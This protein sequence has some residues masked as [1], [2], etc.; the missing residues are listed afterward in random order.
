MKSQKI[1]AVGAGAKGAGISTD[2]V[3]AGPDVTFIE[4]WPA[5]AEA[6]RTNGVLVVMPDETLVTPARPVRV[7]V[8]QDW[9]KGRCGQGDDSNRVRRAAAHR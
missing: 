3:R 9:M 2:L 1:A 7:A 5:H 6:L 4:Q 8:L